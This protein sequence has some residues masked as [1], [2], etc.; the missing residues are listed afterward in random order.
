MA[1]KANDKSITVWTSHVKGTAFDLED[2]G[3]TVT[4]E[5]I[6]VILTM[7]LGMGYDHFVT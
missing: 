4:D 6:I 1:A 2:I 7:G 3:R 5:D